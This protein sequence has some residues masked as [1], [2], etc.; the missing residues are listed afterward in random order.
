[1]WVRLVILRPPNPFRKS[2]GLA[3][4]L[5]IAIAGLNA[6]LT[7]DNRFESATIYTLG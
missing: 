2:V 6:R 7:N 3:F 5:D 1:M 4:Y